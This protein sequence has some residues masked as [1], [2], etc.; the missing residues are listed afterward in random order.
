MNRRKLLGGMLSL[1][2]MSVLSSCKRGEENKPSSKGATL[3]VI[4]HG[5]FG[6]VLKQDDKFRITAYVPTD[7]KHEHELN[8][9]KLYP[10]IGKEGEKSERYHFELS[11]EGLEIGRGSP[12]IDQGFY[13]F[14]FPNIGDWKLPSDVFVAVD[15]PRPDYIT[16]TPPAEP[17]FFGGKL[18]LQPLDH[19]LEYRMSNPEKVRIK[20]GDKYERPVPCSEL[21]DQCKS[22]RGDAGSSGLGTERS[23]LGMFEKM[24]SSC[25]ASDL[26]VFIG[27]G[28]NSGHSLLEET[29]HGIDFFNN[30]LLP[31]LVP[32]KLRKPLQKVGTCEP[33]RDTR[34]YGMLMPATFQYQFPR[35][36]LLEV[37]STVDCQAGGAMG[38]RP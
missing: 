12:R 22:V 24:L 1:P 15:V 3:H 28:L 32:P 19:I 31:T 34:T 27:V 38:T 21:L 9:L 23:Q 30:V 16:F 14:N 13:D 10:P 33:A 7:P 8:F 18:T 11:D 2:V 29:D 4:L 37:T 25:S 17:I 6:V 36:R 5:P 35:P 20:N 26:C